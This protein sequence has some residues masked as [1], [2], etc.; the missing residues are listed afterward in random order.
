MTTSPPPAGRPRQV[1]IAFVLI[2]AGLAAGLVFDLAV[3]FFAEPAPPG[4]NFISLPIAYVVP[5]GLLLAMAYQRRW[6]YVV[7]IALYVI[8]IPWL[9]GSAARQLELGAAYLASF[10]VVDT[11]LYAAIVL[12]LLRPSREWFHVTR[13]PEAAPGM[14]L[15]DPSG[16]HQFRYWQGAWTI[17][18]ADDGQPSTDPLP[19]PALQSSSRQTHAQ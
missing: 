7:F 1:S 18:V 2:G 5:S 13:P 19:P 4:M 6:G 9:W 14:W 11:C 10:L 12:L 15:E 8:G 17:H 16:R 3:L